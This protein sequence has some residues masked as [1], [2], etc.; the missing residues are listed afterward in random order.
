MLK[1]GNDFK[2]RSLSKI[3]TA[4]FGLVRRGGGGGRN[5]S[6]EY[7]K[8]CRDFFFRRGSKHKPSKLVKEA[9]DQHT[10]IRFSVKHTCGDLLLEELT[11]KTKKKRVKVLLC[12]GETKYKLQNT[13]S[14]DFFLLFANFPNNN[15]GCQSKFGLLH[16]LQLTKIRF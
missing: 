14:G 10:V 7:N 13:Q 4:Q 5:L 6:C 11:A 16:L 15:R 3:I 12:L 9:D 2:T 1:R 8:I